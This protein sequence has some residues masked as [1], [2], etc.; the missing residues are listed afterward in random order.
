[1]ETM[2]L[3]NKMNCLH[4]QTITFGLLADQVS[5]VSYLILEV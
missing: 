2:Q 4:D 1:M 3:I 5:M